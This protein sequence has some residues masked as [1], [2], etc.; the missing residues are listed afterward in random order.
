MV[1]KRHGRRAQ[2]MVELALGMFALS[3]VLAALFSLAN[4]ILKGL[5]LQRGLRADAGVSALNATGIGAY[6]TASANAKVK[7]EPLAA[8]YVFGAET[9]AIKESVAMPAMKGLDL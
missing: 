6:A 4:Y 7:V 8:E 9:V 1:T 5:A 2:A 3:L